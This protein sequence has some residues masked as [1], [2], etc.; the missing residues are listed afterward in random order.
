MDGVLATSPFSWFGG[1]YHDETMPFAQFSVDADTVFQV[2]DEFHVPDRPARRLQGQQGRRR[3][4]DAG[5]PA[6]GT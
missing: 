3:R 4:L 6:I 2:L 5:S 1:K